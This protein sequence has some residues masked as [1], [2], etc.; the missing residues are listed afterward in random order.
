MPKTPFVISKVGRPYPD[1][2]PWGTP[3]RHPL[4]DFLPFEGFN[5]EVPEEGTAVSN[6]ARSVREAKI[7]FGSLV[8]VPA[9]F[10]CDVEDGDIVIPLPCK[11]DDDEACNELMETL[12]KIGKLPDAIWVPAFRETTDSSIS[13]LSAVDVTTYDPPFFG[14]AYRKIERVMVGP[15][16]V[17]PRFRFHTGDKV[18][19]DKNGN[20]TTTTNEN[21]VGVCLAPGSV[22]LLQYASSLK[23]AMEDLYSN[24]V[25]DT[26]DKIEDEGLDGD[27]IGVTTDG[28]TLERPLEIRFGDVVNVKDFGAK[29]DGKTNDTNAFNLA[30]ARAQQLGSNVCLFIPV[31]TYL[32]TTLPNVPC[33]GPGVVKFEEKSYG[34][35]ELMFV[36][37][38][39]IQRTANGR[40]TVDFSKMD[41]K[42]L[43][44]LIKQLLPES[45]G[46]LTTDENGKLIIDLDLMTKEELEDFI[47]SLLPEDGDNDSGLSVDINGKLNV[48]FSNMSDTGRANLISILV[49]EGGGLDVDEA[50]K[51]FVDFSKMSTEAFENMLKTLKLTIWLH[52]DKNFY[53]DGTTGDD[54]I[55]PG[56]GESKDKPFKTIKAA[57]Y[58]V[59]AYYNV[60]IYNAYIL[61]AP[62][63]YE[64]NDI[65]L[66]TFASIGGAITIM[67]EG[68][69]HSVTIR[70][71]G[72]GSTFIVTGLRWRLRHL[73][74]DKTVNQHDFPYRRYYTAVHVGTSGALYLEGC[75]VSITYAGAASAGGVSMFLL[76]AENSGVMYVT[77]YDGVTPN[78]VVRKGNSD[79]SVFIQT[80]FG[81]RVFLQ[82]TQVGTQPATINAFGE[83]Y[84]FATAYNG[85]SIDATEV[86]GSDLTIQVPVGKAVTGMRFHV[87]NKG[88]IYV[89]GRGQN[90]FPGSTAGIVEAATFGLYT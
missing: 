60:D 34:P 5:V 39:G 16:V 49:K 90:F 20:L 54:T 32:V 22:Y 40:F 68:D 33:Y 59:T 77:P 76:V 66:N 31:G 71:V 67:P 13:A 41:S 81:G 36:E 62:G 35:F 17:H 4:D 26:I 28:T 63:I 56:R 70:D 37:N 12:A 61:V 30:I 9:L 14:V 10:A 46:G 83:C 43:S 75:N 24:A 78:L 69:P 88:S 42:T 29:G 84:I 3:H 74:I 82:R 64:E 25:K 7:A 57:V 89:G 8:S 38:G 11:C 72:V 87:V 48:D 50:G 79:V 65:R 2:W 45:G 47:N 18:Y 6:I 80:S 1:N 53:V 21:M 86:E 27:K 23:A 19:A 44:E 52:E 73:V 85:A 15:I 55:E 58:Y 51:L